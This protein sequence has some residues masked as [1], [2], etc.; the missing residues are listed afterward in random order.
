[1][2]LQYNADGVKTEQP[3]GFLGRIKASMKRPPARREP[4][5]KQEEVRRLFMTGSIAGC[6]KL[7]LTKTT[8]Y[9]EVLLFDPFPFSSTAVPV[10]CIIGKLFWFC[11][12]P[13][14]LAI[15]YKHRLIVSMC[16]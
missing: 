11:V 3:V 5:K 9:I 1:M 14:H 6:L 12:S 15:E 4:E 7:K 2:F 13:C 10:S 8:S 16:A